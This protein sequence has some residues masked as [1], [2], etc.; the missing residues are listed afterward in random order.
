P[1]S[2]NWE[3]LAKGYQVPIINVSD[4]NKLGEAFEWSLSMQKLV[5]I[6]VDINVE[7]QMKEKNLIF[8]KILEN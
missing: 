8:K 2:I 6:K 7:N 1:K 3:N 5:I 4:F